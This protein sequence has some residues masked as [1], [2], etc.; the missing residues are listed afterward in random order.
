MKILFTSFAYYPE[1]SGVPIVVQYLAE[2][3][4][5]KGHQ[6]IVATRLN[7]YPY[8]KHEII[9]GVEVFRF[10]IYEDAFK[11]NKGDV[12]EFVDFVVKQPKDVLILEFLQSQT[13][14]IFLPYLEQMK[15]KVLVQSH[16]SQG[17]Y[18][19]PFEWKGDLK[20][21][22]A[23]IHNWYRWKKYY[24]KELP[25][26][27]KDIDA[28]IC[29]S[30]GATDLFYYSSTFKKTFILE[31][32][33]DPIF[34][35]SSYYSHDAKEIIN[36]GSKDYIVYLANYDDRKNQIALINE[37]TKLKHK[38]VALILIGSKENSYY[39]RVRVATQNA[40]DEYGC[41][42]QVLTGISRKLFPSILKQA[43]LFVMSSK[44]E[45]Y[46]VSLVEAMAVGLPF[47]STNVG[48]ARI[49]PGG[50]TVNR[51]IDMSCTIDY[52]LNNEEVRNR[53]SIAGR[54]YASSINTY[55]SAADHLENIINQLYA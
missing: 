23:N 29:L 28:G 44:Y 20:H 47:V 21:S 50:V 2:G 19:K 33:A 41:E 7:G 27:A 8:S 52:L 18:L 25:F 6:V 12:K 5:K 30:M 3:L 39:K 4:A 49:L 35:D 38:D 51:I 9:N 42:I 55:E 45:E 31:N 32:A 40:C 34:F 46:P 48:N 36:I 43:K 37:F 53:L 11:R 16:G 26:Y 17:L 10:N 22:V 15:C 1:T 13:A 24:N 14:K 54:E